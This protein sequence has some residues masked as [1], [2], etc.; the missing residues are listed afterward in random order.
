[1]SPQRAARAI[2]LD[3][4]GTYESLLRSALADSSESAR[5]ALP[6]VGA[7]GGVRAGVLEDHPRRV[8]GPAGRGGGGKSRPVV[9][10]PCRALRRLE[11][12]DRASRA[13]ATTCRPRAAPLAAAEQRRR[14]GQLVRFLG[15]VPIEYRRGVAEGHVTVPIEIQEAITFRDGAAEAFGDLQS[16]LGAIRS[17]RDARRAVIARRSAAAARGHRARTAVADPDAV[18][19][20]AKTALAKL[21]STYPDEWKGDNT[22]ADFD[23]IATLLQK[24]SAAA[25]TAATTGAPS[26]AGSRPTHLRARAGAALPRPRPALFQRVEGLFW[27]GADGS[28]GLAQLI[29][30]NSAGEEIAATLAALDL[31]LKESAEAIGEG[32]SRPTVIANTAIITFREGLEAVLILAALMA[33]MVGP[34]RRFR[35]PLLV[36]AA[37]ALAPRQ[38]PGSSRRRSWSRSPN[39]ANGSR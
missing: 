6:D 39:T 30:R 4:L 34:Q 15:L 10:P 36:G 27:Y 26:R 20:A 1:M 14:A 35:R 37:L 28:D 22:Q 18:D 5:T 13:P 25:A 38:S 7:G 21:D 3:L 9:R 12:D 29:R 33:S 24:V 16:Y 8:R 31:S 32:A 11:A 23:V 17:R 19:E 2:R